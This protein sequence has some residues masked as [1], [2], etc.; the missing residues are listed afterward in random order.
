MTVLA[1]DYF[2][3]FPPELKVAFGVVILGL[4]VVG[5]VVWAADALKSYLKRRRSQ[6]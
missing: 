1:Y 4:G 6:P 3:G 5:G 2:F